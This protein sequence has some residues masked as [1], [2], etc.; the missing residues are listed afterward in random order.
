ME[1]AIST[2]LQTISAPLAMN[3]PALFREV[4]SSFIE[5][6]SYTCCVCETPAVQPCRNDS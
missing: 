6:L 3:L 2:A 5:S 1:D 4:F